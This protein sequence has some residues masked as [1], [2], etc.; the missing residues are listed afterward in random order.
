MK[1]D[2]LIKLIDKG[3][4]LKEVS[5]EFNTSMSSIRYWLNKF[6]LT[7]KSKEVKRKKF[8][9]EV[10]EKAKESQNFTELTDKLGRCRNGNGFH[11]LKVLIE[12]NN[13]NVSHFTNTARLSKNSHLIPLSPA[14]TLVYNRLNGRREKTGNLKKALITRGKDSTKCSECEVPNKWNSKE[15]ILQVDHIDGDRLNNTIDNLRF[16]C[17]NCHS[18]TLT[19]CRSTNSKSSKRNKQKKKNKGFTDKQIEHFKKS[20]KVERPSEEII[21][22]DI[23]ELGYKGAGR[24]YGVSDNAVRK[25][26]K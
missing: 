2:K 5:K 9:K 12:E 8:I 22:K 7:S 21:L 15:L 13:I 17:P 16:I 18:Q 1:K 20:R 14:T 25:W 4:T 26:I 10:N 6:D 23:K 24:K 3:Y 11:N 19:Y